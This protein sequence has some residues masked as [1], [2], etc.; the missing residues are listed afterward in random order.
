MASLD[1]QNEDTDEHLKDLFVKGVETPGGERF[2]GKGFRST[3]QEA[4]AACGTAIE[5]GVAAPMIR[6]PG[7]ALA[8]GQT[9]LSIMAAQM[10]KSE[11]KMNGGHIGSGGRDSSHRRLE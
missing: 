5:K 9:P 4:V 8:L 1:G 11:S 3:W 2:G 6:I 10:G 7:L